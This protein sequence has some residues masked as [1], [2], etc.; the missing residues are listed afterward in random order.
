MN[1]DQIVELF[2]Q[3]GIRDPEEKLLYFIHSIIARDTF[4]SFGVEKEYRNY[5]DAWD[6]PIGNSLREY[7]PQKVVGEQLVEG[8]AGSIE[9]T[10]GLDFV[11]GVVPELISGDPENLFAYLRGWH[12]GSYRTL[13]Y[14]LLKVWAVLMVNKEMSAQ[15]YPKDYTKSGPKEL[16]LRVFEAYEQWQASYPRYEKILNFG[17]EE[18]FQVWLLTHGIPFRPE[19]VKT[20]RSVAF[21]KELKKVGCSE[22][23]VLE[24]YFMARTG[25]RFKLK[26]IDSPF[27]YFRQVF[28]K[29]AGLPGDLDIPEDG[30]SSPGQRHYIDQERFNRCMQEWRNTKPI[31]FFG[32]LDYGQRNASRIIESEN[33]M[34]YALVIFPTDEHYSKIEAGDIVTVRANYLVMSNWYGTVMK[35]SELVTVEKRA[36][37]DQR[38]TTKKPVPKVD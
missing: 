12:Q 23:A 27:L 19:E 26:E 13:L 32:T 28:L 3:A 18:F 22:E 36:D 35:F 38:N 34:A 5:I 25:K 7:L 31:D 2:E 21:V 10:N 37:M 17:E 1:T 9:G 11:Q 24:Y 16:S 20:K 33:S 14:S 4:E 8:L 29:A 30:T 6:S 15:P